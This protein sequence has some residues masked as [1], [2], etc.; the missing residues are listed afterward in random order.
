M[1]IFHSWSLTVVVAAGPILTVCLSIDPLDVMRTLGVT[2]TGPIV[3]PRLVARV[4]EAAV[5]LH[6][7]EVKGAIEA[8]A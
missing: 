1:L 7:H 3:R 2:V 5:S 8:A 6:L 4:L